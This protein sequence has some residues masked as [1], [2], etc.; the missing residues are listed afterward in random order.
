MSQPTNLK[1]LS[2]E[3][4]SFYD[5][6]Y[7][8]LYKR[9]YTNGMA[10]CS[11]TELVED[12]LH[13]LFEYFLSDTQRLDNVENIESYLT[14]SLKRKLFKEM[15]KRRNI[16]ESKDHMNSLHVDSAEFHVIKKESENLQI[17]RIRNAISSLSEGE[18]SAIKSR[19]FEDKSYE[20]IAGENKSTKRTVYNQVHSGIK[21]LRELL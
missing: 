12:C 10:V 21:K 8:S 17:K 15:S 2:K 13:E 16:I 18:S 11:S 20:D 19:F 5:R 7:R 14:A 4:T 1:Q 6:L 9:L 3:Q